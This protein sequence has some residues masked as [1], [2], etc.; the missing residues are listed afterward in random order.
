[1]I[2]FSANVAPQS[3][4]DVNGYYLDDHHWLSSYRRGC[5]SDH[6][7]VRVWFHHEPAN[8][9]NEQLTATLA[10]RRHRRATHQNPSALIS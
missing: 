2:G 5:R 3:R 10:H 1:M 4:E 7:A 9:L 6:R 8:D